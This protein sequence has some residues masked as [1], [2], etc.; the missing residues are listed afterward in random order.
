MGG[1]GIKGYDEDHRPQMDNAF[2][3]AGIKLI[4]DPNDRY[5]KESPVNSSEQMIAGMKMAGM[6]RISA[7][8]DLGLDLYT[9]LTRMQR[10]T[11]SDYIIEHGLT[12]DNIIID[13]NNTGIKERNI[14]RQII[15]ESAKQKTDSS[16]SITFNILFLLS[17]P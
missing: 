14:L 9:P 7:R 15:N 12:S 1:I 16:R 6:I 2:T 4:R 8:G 3:G 11:I 13:T 17:S 10:N 5:S